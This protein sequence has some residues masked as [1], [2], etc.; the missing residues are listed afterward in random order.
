MDSNV[1][2]VKSYNKRLLFLG[3]NVSSAD[4]PESENDVTSV[5]QNLKALFKETINIQQYELLI[6]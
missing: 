6:N 4:S 5:Y 2:A 3:E 1:K